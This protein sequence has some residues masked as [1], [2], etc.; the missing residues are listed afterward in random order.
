MTFI[1]NN[2]L[3]FLI[4]VWFIKCT[5]MS[6]SVSD[7]LILIALVVAAAFKETFLAKSKV[8]EKELLQSQ[9]NELTEK[10]DGIVSSVSSLKIDRAIKRGVGTNEEKAL[11]RF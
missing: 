3:E 11:R 1:K 6:P 4:V 7:A 9:I 2:F 5:S 10:L 8:S